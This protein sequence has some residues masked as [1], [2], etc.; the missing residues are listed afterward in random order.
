MDRLRPAFSQQAAG[1]TLHADAALDQTEPDLE[2]A[3]SNND[4]SPP[5]SYSGQANS[6][7]L[8]KRLGD[9]ERYLTEEIPILKNEDAALRSE[10]AKLHGQCQITKLPN[11][12]GTHL[13]HPAG[14][15]GNGIHKPV[16]PP[17]TQA[18]LTSS[19]RPDLPME[20]Q[21]RLDAS[22]SEIAKEMRQSV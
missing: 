19:S 14:K 17:L 10:V 16:D 20:Q 13:S 9:L 12:L 6:E 2:S 5:S 15:H 1:E 11:L 7:D 18:W 21:I 4:A 8:V 3:K 22:V